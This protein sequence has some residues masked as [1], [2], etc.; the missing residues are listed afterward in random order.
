MN[1]ATNKRLNYVEYIWLDGASPT[2]KLRSKTKMLFHQ[3][4]RDL[5]S[6]PEWSFDGS[7]TWQA[8]GRSSDCL[9]KPIFSTSDPLRGG[10]DHYLV[11]CEVLNA[12]GSPHP[13]NKRV[14]LSELMKKAKQQMPYIGFEQEYTLFTGE[15]E[16]EKWPVGWPKGGYPTPQGPFYCGVGAGRVYGR[17]IVEEHAQACQLADLNIYGINAEVMP[18]QWEFQ[19]GYRGEDEPSDPLLIADQL[20]VARYLLERIAETYGVSVSFYNKPISGDW[21]GAGMHTNFSTIATRNKDGG[22]DAIHT[23]IKKLEARHKDHIKQ[24]GH[25]L[26]ARLTGLH[27]TCH[28]DEFKSGVSNRGASIRIPVSTHKDGCG[29]FEDRRPGANADPYI[30]ANLLVDTVCCD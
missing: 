6:F 7:S 21:N 15:L 27:E 11:L 4:D 16:S 24:Y 10:G 19:I 23:A 29:Y 8:L 17:E 22:I 26:N 3:D 18:S 12:D 28:I 1:Q 14:H 25:N 2:Q 20:W 5:S 30:V 9:L 13:T